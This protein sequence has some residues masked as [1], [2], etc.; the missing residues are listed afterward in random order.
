MYY[1]LSNT[2]SRNS[3]ESEVGLKFRFPD[4][5]ESSPIIDGLNEELLPIIIKNN[6]EAIEF[7]IWGIL[8]EQYKEEWSDFQNI[9][10]TLNLDVR[11]IDLNSDYH[12]A[13]IHRRCAVVVSGFFA[14]YNFQGQIY[15]VYVYPKKGEVFYLAGIYNVTYDGFI[16]FTVLLEKNNYYVSKIHNISDSMPIILDNTHKDIWLSDDYSTII[17]DNKSFDTLEFSSHTVAK[18]FYKNNIL[19]DTVLEPVI[20]KDLINSLS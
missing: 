16:T 18:E 7:G 8:P 3:I 2:I 11:S 5:Y 9:R 20:Y 12:Q 1:K 17:G 15:P 6:S 10:N 14:S 19:F 13:L 4:L